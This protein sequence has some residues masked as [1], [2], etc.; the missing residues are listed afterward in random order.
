MS[1]PEQPERPGEE[2][3]IETNP[4]ETTPVE[5]TEVAETPVDET[6]VDT[7]VTSDEPPVEEMP[8]ALAAE[9]KPRAGEEIVQEGR[10]G[11]LEVEDVPPRLGE[12]QLK[13]IVEA[14]MFASPEPL[15]PKTRL[16]S[17]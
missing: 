3:P 2:I 7:L 12:D 17:A 1:D 6:P 4:V 13:A 14:L 11:E 5:D 8:A 16:P 10:I 15:T 9:S